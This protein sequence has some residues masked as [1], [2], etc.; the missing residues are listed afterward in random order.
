[1]IVV[2]RPLKLTLALSCFGLCLSCGSS[3]PSPQS[4][5]GSG[6]SGPTYVICFSDPNARVVSLSGAFPVKPAT[7]VQA[8]EQPWAKDFRRYIGQRNG[9]EEG[10]SVTCTPVDSKNAQGTLKDKAD[11]LRKAGHEVTETGWV[12]AGG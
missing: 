5:S 9:R 2:S 3:Q 8:L 11:S 12:Y 6:G 7:Q 10:S 4:S 1:M